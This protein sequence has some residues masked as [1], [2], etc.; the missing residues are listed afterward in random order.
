MLSGFIFSF[1]CQRSA[2]FFCS[3]I[4]SAADSLLES[5]SR[6]I[7]SAPWRFSSERTL[8]V[9]S[10]SRSASSIV[11]DSTSSPNLERRRSV[12]IRAAGA[13]PRDVHGSED[14]TGNACGSS[15]SGARCFASGG[16]FFDRSVQTKHKDESSSEGSFDFPRDRLATKFSIETICGMISA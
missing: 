4:D 14:G 2:I 10:F 15:V 11:W 16:L 6:Y 9:G 8:F 7:D 3:R 1:S 12:Q 5:V 13:Q